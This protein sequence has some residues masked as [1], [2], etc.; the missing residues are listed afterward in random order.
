M[1]SRQGHP[2]LVAASVMLATIM[3][4]LDTTI[5]NVALPHMRGGLSASLDQVAWV[6][7]SYIVASA[8]MTLP[9]GYLAQRFGRRRVM[10]FSVVGFSVASMLCGQATSITEMIVWRIVQGTFGAAVVPLSQAILLDSFPR[11]KHATAMSWWGM[12]VMVGP[13][14]GPTVGGWLTEYYNWRWVFYINL[15]VGIV[16]FLGIYWF[17]PETSRKQ[18]RFDISGFA[19]LA[20]AVACLQLLLDRG[21]HVHWFDSLEIQLYAVVGILCVYLF[22][23]HV[24]TSDRRFIS[25]ELL[26]DTNFV[27]GMF[28]I[29]V[30]GMVLMGTMALLPPFLQQWQEYPVAS[31]GLLMVPRGVGTILSMS[32]VSYLL[33]FVD[34][35]ALIILGMSVVALALHQMAG[36]TLE[37]EPRDVVLA[38]FVQGAGTGLVTVPTSVLAFATLRMEQRNEGSALYSLGRSMG[39]SIGVSVVVSILTRNMWINQQQLGERL[40]VLPEMW[41]ELTPDQGFMVIPGTVLQEVSR[42][43]AEIAFVNDFHMLALV[44]VATLPLVLLLKVRP[45]PAVDSG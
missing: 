8:V 43:A 2:G 34:P 41:Y 39:S 4:V 30:V 36:F 31:A 18:E 37:V 16:S 24:A 11:E 22:L 44:T 33:R 7:T 32:T 38:G 3:Q 9:V 29:F 28:F 6:L 23:V 14:L 19:L 45:A 26:R 12:G 17:L 40:R 15:P 20:I 5:A 21:G 27:S 35:R 42:Q 25:P 13:V 1:N 10:L